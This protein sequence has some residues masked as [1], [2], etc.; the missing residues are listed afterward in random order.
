MR[1]EVDAILSTQRFFAS[2]VLPEPWDVRTDLEAGE[3]PERPFA[4]IEQAGGAETTGAPATQ[5]LLLPVTVNLYPAKAATREAATDTALALREQVWQAVKWGPDP[6]RPT[7][8][9]IPLYCYDPRVEVHR[10][11][12]PAGSDPFTVTV[13]GETT[14][15]VDPAAT[16]AELADAIAEALAAEDGDI[17]GQDRG[18]GLW[19]IRYG[20]ALAGERI[21]A[22]TIS[23]GTARTMLEGAV[24]PWRGPS[25]YMRVDS[26][27]QNTIRDAS[28][29]TIVMVAVDLR[30]TFGRGLPLPLDQRIVQR[31]IATGGPGG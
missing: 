23:E 8:D 27:S 26:F 13:A 31:V 21:G 18:T 6:H 10:F 16:A 5:D 25:D 20:G 30:L 2:A 28:D 24:A 22:P 7:T 9:R 17:T 12:I 11:S 15:P 3:P 19:D 1:S 29:P 4:L 14:S